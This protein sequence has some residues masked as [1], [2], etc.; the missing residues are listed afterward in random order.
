[1]IIIICPLSPIKMALKHNFAG[2]IPMNS[3]LGFSWTKAIRKS[4]RL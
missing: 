2:Y 1:M 4:S 3:P